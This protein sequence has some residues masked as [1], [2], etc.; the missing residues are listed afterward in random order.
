MP[1]FAAIGA[2]VLGAVSAAGELPAGPP[3]SPAEGSKLA[4]PAR[5]ENLVQVSLSNW[6]KSG[7]AQRGRTAWLLLTMD[8]AKGWHTYW[9]GQNE[10][11]APTTMKWRLPEGFKAGT[12]KFPLPQRHIGGGDL[13]D[14]TLEGTNLIL[15][16]IEVAADAKLGF[17]EIG[18]ELEYLVCQ[19]ACIPGEAA[20]KCRV[21][22]I[23]AD[24]RMAAPTGDAALTKQHARQSGWEKVL[25]AQWTGEGADRRL[26]IAGKPG[27]PR[28][29]WFAPSI[30]GAELQDAVRTGA[31]DLGR[32]SLGFKPANKGQPLPV[33]GVV[34]LGTGADVQGYEI[35]IPAPGQSPVP[36]A[37]IAAPGAATP[38]TADP[39]P[40]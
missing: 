4:S 9:P 18:L 38:A 7:Y 28:S 11:G 23:D 25:T 22:V 19:E 10:T 27:A 40:K 39:S 32:L 3:A 36:P 29:I 31:S 37:A 34:V 1:S 13:L 20:L 14:Y 21:E 2:L 6:L 30:A 8:V 16:P 12:A 5:A 15:V 17:H 24:P 26:E 33:R 35:E